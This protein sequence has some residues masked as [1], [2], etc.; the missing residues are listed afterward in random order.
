MEIIKKV[1]KNPAFLL[2]LTQNILAGAYQYQE[3]TETIEEEI[4]LAKI[5]TE[6]FKLNVEKRKEALVVSKEKYEKSIGE[7]TRLGF[8]INPY[9][10]DSA[11][12]K[13]LFAYL[14]RY[15][16]KDEAVIDIY[17][18][19]GLTD[20][21]HNDFY[22]EYYSPEKERIARYFP[23][24]LIETTKGRYLI[25]EVKSNRERLNYEENKQQYL[26]GKKKIVDEVF[27][28]EIGFRE[29]QQVNKN[30]EYRIIFN[31]SFQQRQ[32]ELLETI[33]KILI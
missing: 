27:A 23:D 7:K 15:L 12:E 30:F 4:D 5:S 28:K 26:A 10:Y 25:I 2:F 19:G 1:N 16:E 18:T 13:N 11:D 33:K 8:H 14:Q 6:E 32:R 17:F 31:A 3:K 9:N 24:F 29:F 22:F 21:T 20:P